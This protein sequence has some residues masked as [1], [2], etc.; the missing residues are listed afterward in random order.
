MDQATAAVKAKAEITTITM[1]DGRKVDFA[2]KRKMLKEIIVDGSKVSVR[3]DFRN[4]NTILFPVPDSILLY[5]AGH[6]VAQKGGD[7]TAGTDDVDDMQ[8]DVEAVLDRLATKGMEGW[9]TKREGGG[10]AGTSILFRAL[11]EH[12]AGKKSP[13][14]IKAQ[15]ALKTPAEK[16][17]M[18]GASKLKPIIE[19]LEAEKA[20]KNAKVDTAHLFDGL[21]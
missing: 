9:N 16:M 3:F 7:E 11:V 14:E 5:A 12:L 20:A 4:G 2:G 15:L 8:L 13:E 17:A 18:R 10:F 6:G 21:E 1:E 19:R